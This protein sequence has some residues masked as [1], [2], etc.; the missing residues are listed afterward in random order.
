MKRSC[1]LRMV[2]AECA[3]FVLLTLA[4]CSQCRADEN[5]GQSVDYDTI[6][7]FMC[8]CCVELDTVE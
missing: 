7:E 3:L 1:S 8:P 6:E 5:K 2:T 4:A